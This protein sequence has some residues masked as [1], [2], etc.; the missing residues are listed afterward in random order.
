MVFKDPSALI[1]SHVSKIL[2]MWCPLFCH[3]YLVFKKKNY[4]LPETHATCNK[5]PCFMF[6]PKQLIPT[7]YNF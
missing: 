3:V 1:V 5:E 6:W 4:L 2:C 7:E